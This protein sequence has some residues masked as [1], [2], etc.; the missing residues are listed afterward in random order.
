[1]Q[2]EERRS[3]LAATFINIKLVLHA[4]IS[5]IDLHHISHK[6][7]ISLLYECKVFIVV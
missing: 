1:M 6:Y 4:H 2:K 5:N 3:S 7:R